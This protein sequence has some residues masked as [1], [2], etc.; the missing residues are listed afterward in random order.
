MPS[1]H[2]IETTSLTDG[3]L[4]RPRSVVPGGEVFALAAFEGGELALSP[5]SLRRR[6]FFYVTG[7]YN[8]KSDGIG[9]K[10]VKEER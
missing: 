9:R 1:F 6:F 3:V 7:S 8:E 5:F 10:C 2:W 4:P